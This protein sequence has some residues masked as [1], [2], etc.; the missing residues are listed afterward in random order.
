MTDHSVFQ[1]GDLELQSGAIL[2]N[3]FIAYKT[4]GELNASRTNAVL[5]ATP[6]GNQHRDIESLIGA[7]MALDPARYFIVIPNL[8]GNGLSISPSNAANGQAG[9]RFP[10]VTLYDNAILQ[11]RLLTGHLGIEQLELAAGFSMGGQQALYYGALFPDRVRRLAAICATARTSPYSFVILDSVKAALKAD[12][13]W[14]DGEFTG[15]PT[16]GLQAVA[17]AYAAWTLSPGFYRDALYKSIGFASIEDY[18]ARA[19]DANFARFDPHNLMAMWWSWQHCDI[20][21]NPVYEG[22]L[23]RALGAIA[24]RTLMMAS[25]SDQFFPVE[26][27]QLDVVKIPDA[28]LK[29]IHSDWGH[30]AGNVAQ[31]AEIRATINDAL[32]E[33]LRS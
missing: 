23:N 6:F 16:R 12:P 13:A 25:T 30:R 14:R 21:A 15:V 31:S 29:T 24:A 19:W 9:G 32:L 8:V 5:Y 27:C 11:H 20:S 7:G 10:N 1:P 4:Y 26:E 28:S 17:R 3:A 18:L 33:L 22:D 2:R